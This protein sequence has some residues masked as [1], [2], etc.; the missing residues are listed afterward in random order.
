MN[1]LVKF[2]RARLDEKQ[3]AATSPA[4]PGEA[5]AAMAG[6]APQ[7]YWSKDRALCEVEADRR[8]IRE[9]EEAVAFYNQNRSA[10]AGE[11]TGL[12]TAIKCRAAVYADHPDYLQEW[13][14]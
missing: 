6:E 7:R 2:Q 14:P 5:S 12:R 8:L 13:A 1:D 4:V 11:V 10:P 3:A 9:Y